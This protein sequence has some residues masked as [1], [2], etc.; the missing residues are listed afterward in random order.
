M[1][2]NHRILKSEFPPIALVPDGN[3]TNWKFLQSYDTDYRPVVNSN[4]R[5]WLSAHKL[6]LSGYALEDLTAYF[7]DSFEQRGSPTQFTWDEPIGG[8]KLGLNSFSASVFELVILSTVPI[9][10]ENFLLMPLNAAGFIPFPSALSGLDNG[11]FDRTHII[12]GTFR[13]WTIDS[14]FSSSFTT[15]GGA[16]GVPVQTMNFSS[17]EPT[18]ADAIYCYRLLCLPESLAEDSPDVKLDSVT[19]PPMRVLLGSVIEKEPALEYMMRL[20]RSYELANQV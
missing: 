7:T 20:K 13:V 17:L 14:T 15:K 5:Y 12:H 6:D 9:A 2:D 1:S 18:A 3:T 4:N 11:N 19:F 8:G 10:D 16:Y